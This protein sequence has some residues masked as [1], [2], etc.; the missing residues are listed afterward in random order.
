MLNWIFGWFETKRIDLAA[1]ELNQERAQKENHDVDEREDECRHLSKHW[2]VKPQVEDGV[3]RGIAWFYKGDA[4][5]QRK[6]ARNGHRDE[7]LDDVLFQ[8]PALL[9]QGARIGPDIQGTNKD[10][11]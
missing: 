3:P 5:E 6:E 10:Q 1:Q 7:A 2:R 11:R 9:R 4:D 8:I